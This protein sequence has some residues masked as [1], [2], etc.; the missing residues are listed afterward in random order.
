LQIT[1]NFNS[2]HYARLTQIAQVLARSSYLESVLP[3]STA[4][5]AEGFLFSDS[6]MPRFAKWKKLVFLGPRHGR[7]TD[8]S[9]ALI[10][11]MR[12]LKIITLLNCHI[13]STGFRDLALHSQITSLGVSG[14]LIG[15]DAF[16]ILSQCQHLR[17][18]DISNTSI[19]DAALIQIKTL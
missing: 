17:R 14:S 9:I 1:T 18:L 8:D 15:D 10:R 13:T 16:D 5:P 3:L 6:D 4:V 12:E 19:T 11:S 7:I 2:W